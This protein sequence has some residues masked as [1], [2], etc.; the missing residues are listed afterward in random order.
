VHVPL[1]NP[2]GPVTLRSDAL[3]DVSVKMEIVLSAEENGASASR[4]TNDCR[5][6]GNMVSFCH[7]SCCN[8]R[9]GM[10][11]GGTWALRGRETGEGGA[12]RRCLGALYSP[13]HVCV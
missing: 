11:L 8:W 12:G 9:R 1:G 13:A 10:G 3:H 5:N 6:E 2:F 4:A 7:R